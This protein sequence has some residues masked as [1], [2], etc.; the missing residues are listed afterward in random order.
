MSSG[1][2]IG[3]HAGLVLGAAGLTWLLASL[4]PLYNDGGHGGRVARGLALAP[5]LVLLGGVAI[6]V[7]HLLA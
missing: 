3:F 1:E 7:Y 4:L 2:V 6:G 5:L